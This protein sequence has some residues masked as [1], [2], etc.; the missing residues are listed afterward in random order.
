MATAY[1]SMLPYAYTNNDVAQLFGKFGKIARVTILREK[2]TRKSRGVA[3]IQFAK[4]F[5]CQT[6]IEAMNGYEVEGFTLSCSL[7]KDNGRSTEFKAKRTYSAAKKCFECGLDGHMSYTCPKNVLGDRKQPSKKKKR[8]TY[9]T[10]PS[11]L[12][13]T[14]EDDLA[15]S[16]FTFVPETRQTQRRQM[17]RDSYFSDKDQDTG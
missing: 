14:A 11:V 16:A 1:V 7:S 4:A 10:L 15:I 17:K 5:D 12:E 8:K 3:F 9:S 13:S 6:A 2:E